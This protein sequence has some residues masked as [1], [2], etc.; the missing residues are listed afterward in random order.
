MGQDYVDLV[1]PGLIEVERDGMGSFQFGTVSIDGTIRTIA[2]LT[3]FEWTWCGQSDADEG[4]GRGWA[5]IENDKLV[6]RIFI[7]G[8]DHSGFLAQR[9]RGARKTTKPRCPRV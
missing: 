7:Y 3:F 2:G 9:Y 6:G 5:Q 4:C 8:G 1:V